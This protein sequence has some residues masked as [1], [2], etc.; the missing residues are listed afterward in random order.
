MAI[1]QSPTE[2]F[3]TTSSLISS[4]SL[5]GGRL[6]PFFQIQLFGNHRTLQCHLLCTAPVG[7]G[8]YA[9]LSLALLHCPHRWWANVS[10]L[11]SALTSVGEGKNCLFYLLCTAPCRLWGECLIVFCSALPLVGDEE[12]VSA[13]FALYSPLYLSGWGHPLSLG[14]WNMVEPSCHPPKSL[15]EKHYWGDHW[16]TQYP[17]KYYQNKPFSFN[18]VWSWLQVFTLRTWAPKP[19]EWL[20]WIQILTCPSLQFCSLRSGW[21]RVMAWRGEVFWKRVKYWLHCW[22]VLLLW[23]SHI[24]FLKES[25]MNYLIIKIM[26]S[27]S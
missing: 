18:F 7:D 4:G 11:C 8:A 22:L 9:P 14:K 15:P 27:A 16:Y 2:H 23:L 20:I 25:F 17:Q 1:I 13:F 5:W 24:S 21:L 26:L 6:G 19:R 10:V 3:P 12:N